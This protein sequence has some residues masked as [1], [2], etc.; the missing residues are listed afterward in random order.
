MRDEARASP[1]SP[2]CVESPGVKN[3][4]QT[5]PTHFSRNDNN[6]NNDDNDNDD[7][8]NDDNDD[9]DDDDDD[10]SPNRRGRKRSRAILVWISI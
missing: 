4:G 2:G 3:G 1:R 6:N 8:D 10:T 9:D 7:N 5:V